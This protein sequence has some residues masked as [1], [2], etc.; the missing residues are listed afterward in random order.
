MDLHEYQTKIL[1]KQYNLPIP[2]GAVIRNINETMDSIAHIG[3]KEWVLKAQIHASGRAQAG[4]IRIVANEEELYTTIKSMIGSRL[5]TEKNA[6]EGQPVNQILIENRI[7][8]IAREIQLTLSVNID[9][10][11]IKLAVTADN[12][13]SMKNSSNEIPVIHQININPITGLQPY[14]CY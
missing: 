2:Q 8:N 11:Y 1:L 5:T 4:G 10:T 12:T 6:P 9:T 13:S 7:T 3:G 14:Q